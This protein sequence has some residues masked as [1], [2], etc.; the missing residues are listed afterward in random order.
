MA[1]PAITPAIMIVAKN[2]SDVLEEPV[3][4]DLKHDAMKLGHC[5]VIR[6]LHAS[7][8]RPE[9]ALRAAQRMLS[10]Y[11][12]QGTYEGRELAL[13]VPDARALF[14]WKPDMFEADHVRFV[15]LE[16]ARVEAARV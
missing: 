5:E 13:V 10:K 6:T 2:G 15:N 14:G 12:E 16:E 9:I 4:A 1:T 8:T 11:H 3:L 7:P